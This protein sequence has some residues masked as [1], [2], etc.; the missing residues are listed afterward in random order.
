MTKP[1]CGQCVYATRPKGHW[2]RIIL[3][4]W[5]GLLFCC[6]HRDAA[7]ELQE[8][9][10][11]A[12]CR[13][14]R[15]KAEPSDSRQRS[16]PDDGEYRR[17]PLSNGK[18]AI[19]DAADCDRLSRYRWSAMERNGKCYAYRREGKR[20]IW[21]HRQIMKAPRNLVVDHKDGNSLNNR[22]SNLHLCTRRQNAFNVRHA[23]RESQYVGVFRCGP[24]WGAHLFHDGLEHSLGLFDTEIEAALARDER[25]MEVHGDYAYL[26]FPHGPPAE[27]AHRRAKL[28]RIS[29]SGVIVARSSL[30]AYPSVRRGSV[31]KKS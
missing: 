26:N 8:V 23:S 22:R 10:A 9:Y 1:C 6:N 21:M 29:I 5:P 19:V 15:W 24:Y 25:A 14:F 11:H 16:R 31:E 30:S 4:R 7:G 27:F 2:I 20:R 3:S 12:V 17:I 13:N 18:F 28:R